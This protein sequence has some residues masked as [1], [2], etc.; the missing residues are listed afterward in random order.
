[1]N[2]GSGENAGTTGTHESSSKFIV[3]GA[4]A[5]A[6][7]LG[8]DFCDQHVMAIRP[9]QKLVKLDY[10]NCIPIARKPK[11]R[12]PETTLCCRTDIHI[13]RI[14]QECHLLSE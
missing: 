5:V 7:I 9:K 8:A 2:A 12:T 11:E 10:D 3:C 14:A 6:A 1:M 13:Q 4:L